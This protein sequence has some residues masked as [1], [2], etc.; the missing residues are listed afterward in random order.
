MVVV[1][2]ASPACVIANN[3]IAPEDTDK[4]AFICRDGLY[5]FKTM[6]FGLCGATATFQRLM[7]LVMAGLNFD[8]CLV[9]LDDIIVF[10]STLEHH[11]QRLRLV[12]DRIRKSGL[13]LKSS[14]CQLFRRSVDFLGHTVS[15]RGIEPQA[16]KI[17]AVAEWPEPTNL[18][19]LRAFHGLCGYYRRFVKRFSERAGALYDLLERG[20]K[21]E[22]GPACRAAFNDL[23]TAL[24]SAPIFAMPTEDDRMILDTDASDEAIGAILS[25]V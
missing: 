9:Y 24:T 2:S 13:K 3:T 5:R 21:Y 17:S 6:P 20:R 16:A 23:K 22:F 7:D 14:K 25:Q 1:V 19:E 10:S 11:L 8:I 4:T 12:L 15:Y 18:R